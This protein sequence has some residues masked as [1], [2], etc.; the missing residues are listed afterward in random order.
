MGTDGTLLFIEDATQM[1]SLHYFRNLLSKNGKLT[2]LDHAM[3]GVGAG[4]VVSFVANPIELV[5]AKL[6]LQYSGYL[7]INA[8]PNYTKDLL[9]V[10][11]N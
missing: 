6:Q 7:W 1:T 5:K 10:S 3:A 8:D 2:V 11:G 4:M 9:I